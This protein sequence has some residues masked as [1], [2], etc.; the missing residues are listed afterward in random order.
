MKNINLKNELTE[1]DFKLF[2]DKYFIRI[3]NY[4]FYKSGDV[5]LSED[6]AQDTFLTLWDNRKKINKDTV[7][8]YLY[9]I[10]GNAYIN[11]IK[12]R[13]VQRKYEFSFTE[14]QSNETPEF[15]IEVKEFEKKLFSAIDELPEKSRIVFLMN[16]IDKQSYAEISTLLDISQKAVEKRMHKALEVLRKFSKTI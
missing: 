14:T 3:K 9:K 5:N 2:F 16:R 8:A 1:K 7:S 15:L 11:E 10:S 13:K 4:I 12:H 6:I